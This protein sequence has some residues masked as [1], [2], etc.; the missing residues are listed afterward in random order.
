MSNTIKKVL[1]FG[2]NG[3][4]GSSFV[5][6]FAKMDD[7]EV[8]HPRHSECDITKKQQLVDIFNEVKPDLV[9]NC[10]A[11]LNQDVMESEPGQGLAVNLAGVYFL[12][13]LCKNNNC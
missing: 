4:L 11:D 7:I 8:F 1:I 5:D 12:S 2:G 13:V 9:I 10:V 6:F 3:F